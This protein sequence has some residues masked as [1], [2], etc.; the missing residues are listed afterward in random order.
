MDNEHYYLKRLMQ[1]ELFA[2]VPRPEVNRILQ[3]SED[4]THQKGVL[5]LDT[6]T[7]CYKFYFV[8][9][10][11]IKAYVYEPKTDRQLTLKL[12]STNDVF[13]VLSF[14][15]NITHKMYYETLDST[16]L[17]SFP[18]SLLKRWLIKNPPVIKVLLKRMVT[19]TV[20]LQESLTNMVMD[21]IPTRLAKLLYF[22]MNRTTGKVDI[23]GWLCH[24]ELASLI[25][26]TRCVLNRH[27]QVFKGD[28]IIIVT[29]KRIIVINETLL[30][31]LFVHCNT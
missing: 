1:T 19:D 29:N 22:H 28:K 15:G 9:S 16:T 27:L 31:A 20:K 14:M 5:V 26:T 12:L 17:L 11:N 7:V 4:C 25:G 23:V 6:H 24:Q 13:D 21:D 3:L 30:K 2:K 18:I 10:G 8:I